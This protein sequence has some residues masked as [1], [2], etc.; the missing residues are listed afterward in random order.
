MRPIL[1]LAVSLFNTSKGVAVVHANKKGR[2]AID[3]SRLPFSSTNKKWTRIVRAE[4]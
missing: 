3:A 1:L 2:M 4:L